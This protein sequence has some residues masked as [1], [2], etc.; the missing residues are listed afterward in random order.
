MKIDKNEKLIICRMEKEG[1]DCI[2]VVVHSNHP[3][4]VPGHRFD[5][6]FLRIALSE[7]YSVMIANH[8]KW[9]TF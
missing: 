5:Y 6:G 8:R 7:G 1:S 3:R 4:F 2:P 9:R